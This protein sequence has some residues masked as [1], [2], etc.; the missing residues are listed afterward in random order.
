MT[1]SR[2]R[3]Q[4]EYR[5]A[6]EELEAQVRSGASLEELTQRLKGGAVTNGAASGNGA[7]STQGAGSLAVPEDL[8]GIQ[9]YLRWERGGK[10]NYSPEEQQVRAA[11]QRLSGASK[12]L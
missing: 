11:A 9:A 10:K 6:R 7:G 12:C 8:V 2:M 3:P 4:A 5:A 1:A